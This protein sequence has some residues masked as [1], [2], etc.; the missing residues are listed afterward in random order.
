MQ[1]HLAGQWL[2]VPPTDFSFGP[3]LFAPGSVAAQL[4]KYPSPLK[5]TVTR[6]T[7]D[8]SKVVVLTYQDG[9]KLY[10][11]NSGPAYPL[12]WDDKVPYSAPADITDYGANV[13]IAEPSGA[14]DVGRG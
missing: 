6:A 2:D 14:V 8:G 10:V 4:T 13:L 7:L 5:P 1:R 9:S 12:R 3:G 11:A